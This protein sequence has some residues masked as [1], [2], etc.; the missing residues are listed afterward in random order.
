MT[1]LLR[2]LVIAVVQVGLVAGVGGKLLY[3][4]ETL[5]RVWVQTTGIDPVM[6]IRGRYVSLRLRVQVD[7]TIVVDDEA[8]PTTTGP[9]ELA[10]V[11][12]ALHATAAGG[13]DEGFTGWESTVL[14]R[15]STPTGK[16]WCLAEPVVFFLP[17]SAVDPTRLAPDDQLWAEVTVP[18][19]GPPRPIR[20][21]VR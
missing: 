21:E 18:P 17:E 4:R 15:V 11:D 5:S 20:L 16:V 10:V 8:G 13:P 9:M 3:D 6:P 12:G 19:K 7:P 2:G 1:P 14:Q